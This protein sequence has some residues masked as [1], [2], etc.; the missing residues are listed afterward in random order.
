MEQGL[1]N[2]F[3]LSDDRRKLNSVNLCGRVDDCFRGAPEEREQQQRGTIIVDVD[4]MLLCSW[5]RW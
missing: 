5:E 3:P 1:R 2:L 4:W